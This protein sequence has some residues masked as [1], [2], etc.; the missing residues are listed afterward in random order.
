[1]WYA[2]AFI[3]GVVVGAV[4]MAFVKGAEYPC[5]DCIYKQ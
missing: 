2:L 3:A 5:E 4:T 1:M